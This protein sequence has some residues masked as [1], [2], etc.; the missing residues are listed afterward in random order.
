MVGILIK[1][2]T[3]F[4]I[5]PTVENYITIGVCTLQ[6]HVIHLKLCYASIFVCVRPYL[7]ILIKVDT[8]NWL[9]LLSCNLA[10]EQLIKP[11]FRTVAPARC[12]TRLGHA[13]NNDAT[14]STELSTGNMNYK[15]NSNANRDHTRARA[16]RSR[17]IRNNI[18]S[19]DVGSVM[20]RLAV[21]NANGIK[22][23]VFELHECLRQH[24]IEVLIIV[25]THCVLNTDLPT[26]HGYDC[27]FINRPVSEGL[28]RTNKHV[29]IVGGGGIAIYTKTELRACVIPFENNG[30]ECHFDNLWIQF[31]YGTETL[32]VGAVYALQEGALCR[33]DHNEQLYSQL[34][35]RYKECQKFNYRV[36]LGG[37]FNGHISD[38]VEGIPGNYPGINNN[39]QMFRD[40]RKLSKLNLA[41]S[42]PLAK[43]LWTRVQPTLGHKS[44]IDFVL[45][46]EGIELQSF[47]VDE[48]QEIYYTSS[49]HNVLFADFKIIL[50]A[51][52]VPVRNK[53]YKRNLLATQQDSLFH[54][55][56][57]EFDNLPD[58]VVSP[59]ES[60]TA[61]LSEATDKFFT[62]RTGSS[63]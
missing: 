7:G 53:H 50:S 28:S 17:G 55:I 4:I 16:R 40:F 31:P 18:H 52:R 63:K 20:I 54:Y 46:E 36:I 33:R 43:G 59:Y 44:A 10:H 61:I 23:R 21:L 12:E 37:D 38:D 34:Y 2:W 49:D 58:L 9:L 62:V 60:T 57:Q 22:S 51:P 24:D 47:C 13:P 30:H 15:F 6:F 19:C 39:G 14:Q 56:E 8:L 32:A 35:L 5:T 42:S 25:E 41:N 45:F 29:R 27:N 3:R 1:N 26:F 48:K 11:K